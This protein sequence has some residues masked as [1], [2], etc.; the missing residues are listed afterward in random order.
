MTDTATKPSFQNTCK[1]SFCSYKSGGSAES[2]ILHPLS[3]LVPVLHLATK[4]SIRSYKAE[5]KLKKK[6]LRP[7]SEQIF[8]PIKRSR[9]VWWE[10]KK[11]DAPQ[12]RS[13]PYVQ[14]EKLRRHC[15]KSKGEKLPG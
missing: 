3:H 6:K 9:L 4:D 10:W 13:D 7:W 12:N 8:K 15:E 14:W 5:V 11:A 2:D 1:Q